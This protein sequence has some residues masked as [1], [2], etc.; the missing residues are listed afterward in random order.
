MSAVKSRTLSLSKRGMSFE[1]FMWLF[2]R[3]SA[4]AMYSFI[5]TGFIGALL[6]GARNHM[7]FADIMRWALM[8]NVTHVQNTNLPDLAPWETSF[9]KLVASALLC[10]AAAHGVHGVIV[11]LD[12]Y[13]AKP[14]QRQ[15]TRIVCFTLFLIIVPIGIYVIWTS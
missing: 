10:T 3:L 4:L 13:L 8:P 11:I 5:L 7:N 6:M 12:D 14:A 2:T 1:T 15:W 9:W